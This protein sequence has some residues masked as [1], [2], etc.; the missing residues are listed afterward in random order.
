LPLRAGLIILA[1]SGALAAFLYLGGLVA[2]ARGKRTPSRV[3]ADQVW[4][5]ARYNKISKGLPAWIGRILPNPS[6]RD[7]D[8]S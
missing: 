1:L 5:E 4:T 8:Q 6:D 3:I 7:R 2:L